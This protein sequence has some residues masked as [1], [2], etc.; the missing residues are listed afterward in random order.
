MLLA[1][2]ASNTFDYSGILIAIL[3]M[4]GTMTGSYFSNR[5]S[6]ALISY[7][8]ES[9]EKKVEVHNHFAE[10]MFKIEQDQAVINEQL[11][12]TD[13]RISELEKGV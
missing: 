8:L 11:K 2:L 9:L 12:N 10:R 5:K 13:K 3:G 7:R 6:Q 4:V 1:E